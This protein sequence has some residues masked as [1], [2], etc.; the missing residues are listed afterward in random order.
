[1]FDTT[2]LGDYVVIPVVICCFVIGYIL[3]NYTKL[4][5]NFI[6]LIMAIAGVI[7]NIIIVREN[8][9]SISLMTIMGGAFTG[10]ASTGIYEL[11]MNMFNMKK[12]KKEET[13]DNTAV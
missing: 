3:K 4:P 11:V 9:I 5:N 13:T 1:M 2:I 10:L 8:D 7:F 6:P 12:H